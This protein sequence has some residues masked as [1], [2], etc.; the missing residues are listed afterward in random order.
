MF[1]TIV[2]TFLFVC[3]YFLKVRTY[4]KK[5]TGD[6]SSLISE[7]YPCHLFKFTLKRNLS[8]QIVKREKYIEGSSKNH[9][10]E[11]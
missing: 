1:Y 7:L 5:K 10:E 3:I 6:I 2:I 11:K 8:M 4:V 9:V